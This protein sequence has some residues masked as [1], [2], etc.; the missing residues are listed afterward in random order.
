MIIYFDVEK[1]EK[2]YNDLKHATKI[3]LL[4]VCFAVFFSWIIMEAVKVF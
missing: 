3:C 4:C 1:K 2:F